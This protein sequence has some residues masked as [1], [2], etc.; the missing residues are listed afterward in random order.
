M[1]CMAEFA[2]T[3]W[4]KREKNMHMPFKTLTTSAR[5]WN[6]EI[7]L[8]SGAKIFKSAPDLTSLHPKVLHIGFSEDL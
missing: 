7:S 1:M 4:K 5:N 6:I 2:L 8:Y 3:L